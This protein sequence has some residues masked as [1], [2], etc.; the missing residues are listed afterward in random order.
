GSNGGGN[1]LGMRPQ[2][3]VPRH[4]RNGAERRGRRRAESVSLALH[5]QGRDRELVELME[6]TWRW[7]ARAARRRLERECETEHRG[8]AGGI[9]GS[10]RSPGAQGSSAGDQREAAQLAG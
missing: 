8:C 6:A 5:H 7:I 3:V 2:A 9:R 4:S 10:A 1:S